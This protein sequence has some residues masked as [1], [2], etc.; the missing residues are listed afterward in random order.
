M[1]KSGF[2]S[3]LRRLGSRVRRQSPIVEAPVAEAPPVTEAS[4]VAE[5]P[6]SQG[7]RVRGAV[8]RWVF[9]A[10]ACL[11]GGVVGLGGYTLSYASGLSYLADDP[12]ACV[13]CHIM[14]EQFEG[15]SHG[16]H[17][18]VATCNDCHA[19]HDNFVHKYAIKALN[20]F[21]HSYAF[22]TGDFPD[23][24]RIRPINEEVAREACL[25][26]HGALTN[27][28]NRANTAEPTDCLRCHTDMGH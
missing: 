26:C 28:M 18:L 5:A 17:H 10:L 24:I 7:R 21:R 25:R 4:P 22:T 8:P 6:P 23:P 13:N 15:W 19:P 14:R 16:P 2:I 9:V 12:E 3:S 1:P 27:D 20:G 11:F